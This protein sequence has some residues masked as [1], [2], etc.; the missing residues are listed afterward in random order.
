MSDSAVV[1]YNTINPMKRLRQILVSLYRGIFQEP[2][3]LGSSQ[4]NP[5]L[6]K[7]N[8]DGYSYAKD[9][10]LIVADMNHDELKSDK[11]RPIIVTNRQTLVFDDLFLNNSVA[12]PWPQAKGAYYYKDASEATHEKS[13]TVSTNLS[14]SV[15]TRNQDETE[16]LAYVVSSF[17]QYFKQ[18]IRDE[19]NIINIGPVQ[20]S[21]VI[22]A[23]SD[24][25]I[26]LYKVEISASVTTG[27]QWVI[28]ETQMDK[29]ALKL[30]TYW[31]E[32]GKKPTGDEID[33]TPEIKELN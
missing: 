7:L 23:K 16:D 24:S 29:I 22:P 6:I 5:W 21:T 31:D 17:L 33:L 8:P 3:L 20:C 13:T 9:S 12:A 14:L 10:K 18:T 4:K 27:V 26:D 32:E 19:A 11:P 2:L 30:K 25:K 15:L 28:T 1:K